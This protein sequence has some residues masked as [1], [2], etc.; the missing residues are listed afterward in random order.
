METLPLWR[1]RDQICLQCTPIGSKSTARRAG[2]RPAEPGCRTSTDGGYRAVRI[3]NET[4][5]RGSRS[6]RTCVRARISNSLLSYTGGRLTGSNITLLA[7]GSSA[8][9]DNP[10]GRC[11]GSGMG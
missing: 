9:R 11:P 8:Q 3:D 1:S 2:I 6:A 10:V 4:I 7:D 5:R